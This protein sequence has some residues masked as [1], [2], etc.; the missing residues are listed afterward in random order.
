MP[1]TQAPQR[2]EPAY[3]K[4]RTTMGGPRLGP[5]GWVRWGWRQLTSMRTAIL[6]LLLLALA[7]IPGSLFPQR[8]VDPVRVRAFVEDHP[9]LAPWLDRLFLFDVFSS[10]WFASIY[11][12]LMISLV[13]CIVPRT[14]QHAGPC[15]PGHHGH[16][17]A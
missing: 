1:D 16:H 8:S 7:A 4:D 12:L 3:P 9:G 2:I 6:L 5:L 13:G 11:L 14:A 15:G 10:P 17:G